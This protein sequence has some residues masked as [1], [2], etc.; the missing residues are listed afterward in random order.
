MENPILSD[1]GPESSTAPPQGQNGS[2]SDQVAEILKAAQAALGEISQIRATAKQAASSIE[3]S[4]NQ[5]TAALTDVQTKLTEISAVAT[6]ANATKT[7]ITDDQ[8]VIA[9]KSDHIQKAQEHADKV[10][11]DL[12][13][14][15]TAATQSSTAAE[16]QATAA[17][18][19]AEAATEAQTKTGT[20]KTNAEKDAAST[21]KALQ[22]AEASAATAKKL[23]DK[24]ETVEKRLWEYET[25]LDKLKKQCA[26]QLKAIT[27]LLPGA[28][29]AGLA[30]SFDARRKT[31]LKPHNIWQGLFVGSILAIVALAV[32]GLWQVHQLKDAPTYDELFRL[33]LCRL[34]IA[35]A[36]VWL[37]L[38]S[39]R[40]AALAKRLEEDYGFKAATAEAFL[41]FHKQMTEIGGSAGT[42]KPLAKLCEDTLTTIANPPGRI[43]DRHKLTVTPSDE[44]KEMAKAAA[45]VLD[46]VKPK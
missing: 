40:E 29:T 28:T 39:S 35:G 19:S 44:L 33:W 46:A 41:G 18:K 45:P 25:E 7:K 16:G 5:V 38:H 6:Q 8:A 27:D 43:Y 26:D 13:R 12:D 11:A 9:T 42:N 1:Y 37:A 21:E 4:Q 17:K 15:F 24:S 30:H 20:S 10:R 23:A 32:T 2:G 36:L 3:S 22:A 34:P 14:A 31:F